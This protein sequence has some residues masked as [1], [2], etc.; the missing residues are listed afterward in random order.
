[1]IAAT[2]GFGNFSRRRRPALTASP[3]AKISAASSLVAFTISLRLPP[4]KKVFFALAT[5]TP[6]TSASSAY[7]RST[8][9]AIESM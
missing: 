5:T 7:R 4:A 1:M 2:T 9:A 3:S 6:V 8:A